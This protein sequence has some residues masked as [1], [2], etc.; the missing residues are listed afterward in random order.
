MKHRLILTF[1]VPNLKLW[2]N[3][4]ASRTQIPK[5]TGLNTVSSI[6]PIIYTRRKQSKEHL[7][8]F[9]NLKSHGKEEPRWMDKRANQMSATFL[10]KQTERWSNSCLSSRQKWMVTIWGE[11]RNLLCVEIYCLLYAWKQLVCFYVWLT[12]EFKPNGT[13]NE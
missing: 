8:P 12:A 2:K 11:N 6:C 10:S 1:S 13:K 9:I 5:I 4:Q 3:G 7:A